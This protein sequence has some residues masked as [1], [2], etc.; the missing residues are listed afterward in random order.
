MSL[1]SARRAGTLSGWAG[2]KVESNITPEEMERRCREWFPRATERQMALLRR[3]GYRAERDTRGGG[4]E[5]AKVEATALIGLAL[6]MS[7]DAA[8]TRVEER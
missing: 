8:P 4:R 3:L 1:R 5:L 2:S 6:A 7:M